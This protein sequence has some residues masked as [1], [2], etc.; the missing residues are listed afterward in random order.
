MS[1]SEEHLQ[2][3]TAVA[4]MIQGT[5]EVWSQDGKR[6]YD[7]ATENTVVEVECE[8][9]EGKEMICEATFF[10]RGEDE[11]RKLLVLPCDCIVKREQGN[12]G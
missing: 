10:S 1:E 8:R 7:V 2:C 12:E 4:E 6:R 5:M 11:L 9:N 3:K